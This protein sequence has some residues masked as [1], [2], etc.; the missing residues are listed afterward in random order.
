VYSQWEVKTANKVQ[1]LTW[2]RLGSIVIRTIIWGDWSTNKRRKAK[3]M[4]MSHNQMWNK[5]IRIMQTLLINASTTGKVQIFGHNNT[6][7]KLAYTHKV[8]SR[9]NSENVCCNSVQNLLKKAVF[10]VVAPSSLVEVYRRFRG[11]CYFHH[12]GLMAMKMEAAS[13][14]E[15]SVIFYQTTRHNNPEDSHL[16]TCRRENLISYS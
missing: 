15:T 9:L 16:H 3:H 4:F 5:I 14:S 8:K 12:Q 2:T 6:K 11:A 13:T 1:G 10:W 7:T